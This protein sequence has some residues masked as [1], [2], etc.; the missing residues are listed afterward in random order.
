MKKIN[1]SFFIRRMLRKEP[2]ADDFISKSTDFGTLYL[3]GRM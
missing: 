1:A 2:V 3:L